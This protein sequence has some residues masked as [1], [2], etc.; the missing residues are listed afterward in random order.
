MTKKTHASRNDL[1]ATEI[2]GMLE[3]RAIEWNGY[4]VSFSTVK[5]DID[6]ALFTQLSEG[7]PE[8]LC[9]S[10]HWGYVFK[11]TI[12]IKYKDREETLTAGDAYYMEPGHV[13]TLMAAGTEFLEFSP[14]KEYSET[15]AVV[16]KNLQKMMK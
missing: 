14:T 16:M 2:P 13:A 3:S 15:M 5:K 10:P 7:L 11:G 6:E 1:E 9:H 12:K 4:S 8:G